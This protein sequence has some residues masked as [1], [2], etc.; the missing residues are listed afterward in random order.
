[1]LGAAS[2][3]VTPAEDTVRWTIRASSRDGDEIARRN[4]RLRCGQAV[5]DF[6]VRTDRASY[7]AGQTMTL[8]ALAAG[9][10]PV[11]VDLIKDGQT[12]A[13]QTIDVKGGKGEHQFDLPPDLFG[14]VELVAYRFEGSGVA[15][16]KRRVLFIS[17]P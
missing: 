5:N 9:V 10:E 12:L 17:P 2:F 1:E 11:F 3:T 6:L 14:T 15:A 4:D 7:K 13:S 8:T 16:R